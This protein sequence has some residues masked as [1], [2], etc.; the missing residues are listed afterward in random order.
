MVRR[1]VA[2]LAMVAV[3]GCSKSDVEDALDLIEEPDRKPVPYSLMGVNAF[4]NDAR[5]GTIEQQF[6]EVQNTLGLNYVRVLFAWSNEVQPTPS[7]T[8]NFS[9]YDDIIDALPQGV[10]ALV[11]IADMPQWMKEA[12]NWID[13]DPRKTYLERWIKPVVR[14]YRS[15]TRI[16][17]FQIYNEP[18]SSSRADNIALGF[19]ENPDNY[20]ELLA[21]AFDF[22]RDT[23]PG[24]SVISAATTA[25]NQD[26][27]E[28]IEYNKGMRAAGAERYA[29]VYGV[30]Y[31]GKL[32]ENVVRDN[33]VEDFLD[34]STL[35]IWVTE[36][37]IQGVN[38]Q[39]EYVERTWPY[40]RE[41]I[42]QIE[43]FYYYELASSSTSPDSFGLRN[44]SSEFPISDLYRNLRDR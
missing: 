4:V 31:Y 29:D 11:V 30:H 3:V 18:N 39:L 36:S 44:L 27:P 22:I 24:K 43:R 42:P 16:V 19:V 37:G 1:L 38:R 41:K 13:G 26:F 9:F 21:G 12:D 10:E 40:L 35:P 15:R 5:F 8:P 7:A 28:T 6:R 23:A 2:L 14:R 32:Y 17:G 34:K 33:G 20:V 25:I